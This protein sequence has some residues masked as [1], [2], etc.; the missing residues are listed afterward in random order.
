MKKIYFV[1]LFLTCIISL[2]SLALS[3]QPAVLLAHYLLDETSGTVA[4]DASG[5]GFDGT[6]FGAAS[7]VEGTLGG[8]L[9]FMGTDSVVLPAEAMELTA[10]NGSV[11]FWMNADVPTAI[12]TMFWG[13][14]NRTGGGFGPENEMH[15]HLES[16][17]D[18]WAGGELS[19]WMQGNPSVHIFSDPAKGTSA[20]VAPVNP[21]LLG[22]LQWHHVAATWGNSAVKLYI[23]G[24]KIMEGGYTP[25]SPVYPLSHMYLGKMA[26]G[27]R[28]YTGKLD[29]VRIY[30]GILSDS[31][32]MFL[33]NKITNIEDTK[34]K[35]LTEL[36]AYPN[37]ATDNLNIRFFSHT[38][39]KASVSLVSLTGQILKTV[40]LD[41]IPDY[42]YV[43][44]DANR[45]SQGVYFVD[46]KVDGNTSHT[47]V[48]IE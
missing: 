15:I 47:K 27:G 7:W 43:S 38:S 33:F 25:T 32:I 6:V 5:N 11:A 29:D 22:D 30:S 23:D 17:G 31:Q 20:A 41:A 16:A 24:L 10:A 46:L 18:Y 21:T 37:P 13:G 44:F 45:Y 9:E 12:Y 34:D 2:L 19:F 26:G 48:V 28:T 14:D 42:N 39:G 8:A 36:T 35:G 1:K 4:A 40:E 3:A